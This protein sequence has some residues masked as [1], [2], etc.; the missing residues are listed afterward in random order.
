MTFSRCN[1]YQ[2]GTYYYDEYIA[3]QYVFDKLEGVLKY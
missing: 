3:I 2:K 1:S